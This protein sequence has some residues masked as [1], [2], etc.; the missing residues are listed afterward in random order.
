MKTYNHF[1][2]DSTGRR[3]FGSNRIDKLSG[4][5]N[6]VPQTQEQVVV[7]VIPDTHRDGNRL[8][9]RRTSHHHSGKRGLK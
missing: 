7:E 3:F 9:I 4:L 5:G 8:T 6:T 2:P 1:Q